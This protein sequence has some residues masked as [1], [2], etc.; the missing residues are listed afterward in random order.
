[1]RVHRNRGSSIPIWMA[2]VLVC[3][4]LLSGEALG[5]VEFSSLPP[6]GV[7]VFDLDWAAFK[8]GGDSLRIECYYKIVNPRLSYVRRMM[9]HSDLLPENQPALSDTAGMAEYYVAAYEIN[10]IL[11][12]GKDPQV[13][14][15]SA[16]E[17]YA[18]PTFEETRNPGGYLVNI[19]TA[20]VPPDDYELSVT[21][22]DRVSSNSYTQTQ[23]LALRNASGKDWPIGGPMF[24]DPT[25]EVT[26]AARFERNGLYLVPSVTRAFAATKDRIAMYLEVYRDAAPDVA[27]LE[28]KAEQRFGRKQQTDTIPV[29][30]TEALIPIVYK[31][32]LVGF[33]SGEATLDIRLRDASGKTLGD[34]REVPFWV[35]WSMSGLVEENWEDAVDMLVHIATHDDLKTLRATPPEGRVAAFTAFWKS[36]DPTPQTEDN[37]WQDEYYR[38]IRHADLHFTT[39]FMRGW[40]T[41]YGTVYVKYGEPDEIERH[42]FERGSKPY[43]MWYY[44]AQRRRFL[45]VD[46]NG[47]GEYALQYPYD[48]IVR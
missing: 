8:A 45:F 41:D 3:L 33:K 44:Y 28:I 29:T 20:T 11:A 32:Q 42:P 38:R 7:P 40:R 30:S 16:R 19:L 43:Q 31:S 14:T 13:A 39:A 10:A 1:M 23:T 2:G 9:K 17:N 21:L 5:Q 12:S 35:D 15:V 34:P 37:E 4:L 6:P 36:K 25:A 24:F 46:V 27:F 47:N 22:T 18:L 48:G 26:G